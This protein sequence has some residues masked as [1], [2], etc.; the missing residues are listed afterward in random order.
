M[1]Q[2]LPLVAKRAW[3]LMHVIFDMLKKGISKAKIMADLNKMIKG[4]K[5]AGKSPMSHHLETEFQRS[6]ATEHST[7]IWRV[8]SMSLSHVGHLV[9][10]RSIPRMSRLARVGS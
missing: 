8:V 4:G 3:S 9:E 6:T 2:K 1:E 5:I 7:K 10:L